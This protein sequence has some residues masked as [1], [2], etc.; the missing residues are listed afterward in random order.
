LRSLAPLGSS[1]AIA[2]ALLALAYVEMAE[3]R[4]GESM[5]LAD[6]AAARAKA[7]GW[8]W[9]EAAALLHAAECAFRLNGPLADGGRARGCL[10]AAHEI[11]DRQHSIYALALLAWAAA[12][13]A[14][15]GRAGRLWGAI[16]AE[17]ERG[18][19]GQWEAEQDEYAQHVVSDDEA[20]ER[21]RG[22]GLALTLDEA[23]ELALSLD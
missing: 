7:I 22:E 5:E 1:T 13:A 9:W 8:R 18:R 10:A 14:D 17:T 15:H 16:E 11:G 4:L 6:E 12:A 23:V 20:F 3:G 21:G 2:Q 19:I